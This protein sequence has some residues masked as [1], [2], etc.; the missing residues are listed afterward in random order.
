[1]RLM[2]PIRKPLIAVSALVL[3]LS[4]TGCQQILTEAQARS[5]HLTS[6]EAGLIKSINAYRN[7]RGLGSLRVHPDV[8]AKARR[9]AVWMAAGGCGLGGGGVPKI[10]HSTLS[11]QITV[12]WGWL[13][14]NVALV[15]GHNNVRGAQSAFEHSAPHAAT[16]ASKSARYV[17]VGVA[18]HGPYMYVAEEYMG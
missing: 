10:C 8:E 2:R 18:H 16:M 3:G 5:S 1:M 9:W 17:G 14:E 11:D 4:L 7:A 12:R 6:T 13:A 15:G